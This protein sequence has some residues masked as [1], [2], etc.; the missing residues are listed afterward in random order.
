MKTTITL[1]WAPMGTKIFIYEYMLEMGPCQA[2][3]N[4]SGRYIGFMN[5]Y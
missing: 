4:E 5:T 1:L 2:R 3:K